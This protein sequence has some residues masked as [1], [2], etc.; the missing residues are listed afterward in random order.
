MERALAVQSLDEELDQAVERSGGDMALLG[1][2]L[3][4]WMKLRIMAAEDPS[5]RLPAGQSR[6]WSTGTVKAYR[7]ALRNIWPESAQHPRV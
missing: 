4:A 1:P 2:W 3:R 5:H 7:S 6:R